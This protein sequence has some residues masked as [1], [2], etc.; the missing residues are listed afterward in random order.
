MSENVILSLIAVGGTILGAAIGALAG[1]WTTSRQ[2][3]HQER[4]LF[5]A[6]RLDAFSRLLNAMNKYFDSAINGTRVELD[7]DGWQEA[8]TAANL[9]CSEETAAA[10][11]AFG[12]ALPRVGQVV[13]G[14]D[15]ENLIE[16]YRA[17]QQTLR[18]E[19]GPEK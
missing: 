17:L 5:H 9:L 19:L 1:W 10:I 14:R 3:Q 16:K 12:D 2:I 13:T 15:R 8:A 11:E 7:V 6:S 18:R 4:T